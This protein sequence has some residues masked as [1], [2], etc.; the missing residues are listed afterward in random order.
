MVN[1]YTLDY[2][3][4]ITSVNELSTSIREVQFFLDLSVFRLLPDGIYV[5]FKNIRFG[6]DIIGEVFYIRE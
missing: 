2:K 3:L 5:R 4:C 1:A 6:M